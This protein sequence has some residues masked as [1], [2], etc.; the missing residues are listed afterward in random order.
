MSKLLS[1][2][3]NVINSS[4]K[5]YLVKIDKLFMYLSIFCVC[6]F[7][8]IEAFRDLS[9]KIAKLQQRNCHISTFL[10][11]KK[12][13]LRFLSIRVNYSNSVLRYLAD[14]ADENFCRCPS[15]I[16]SIRSFYRSKL[17]PVHNAMVIPRVFIQYAL[18]L[19]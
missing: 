11:V 10:I 6:F 16:T 13:I 1:V 5:H 18:Y 8:K 9:N 19:E 17:S 15:G 3:I 7:H 4:L 14:L 2:T 12:I